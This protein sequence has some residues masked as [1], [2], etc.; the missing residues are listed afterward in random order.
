MLFSGQLSFSE[1]EMSEEQCNNVVVE[2][3]WDFWMNNDFMRILNSGV[4]LYLN[5]SRDNRISAIYLAKPEI[6]NH[7]SVVSLLKSAPVLH[8]NVACR[9]L[10]D[11]CKKGDVE[12]V[13]ELLTEGLA[14]VNNDDDDGYTPLIHATIY[15]QTSVVSLLLTYKDLALDKATKNG[16]TALHFTCGHTFGEG[17]T[18]FPTFFFNE[19]NK[20]HTRELYFNI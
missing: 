1:V 6:Y 4:P 10:G 12:R 7:P 15:N 9:A 3:N 13:R 20:S 17:G 8:E 14:D 16:Y 19:V 2:V 5:A 11:A 18:S